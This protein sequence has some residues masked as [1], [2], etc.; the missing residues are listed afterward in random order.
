MSTQQSEHPLPLPDRLTRQGIAQVLADFFGAIASEGRAVTTAE[1]QERYEADRSKSFEVHLPGGGG[2][3][4]TAT[5]SVSHDKPKVED[6]NAFHE[7]IEA[8]YPPGTLIV[9]TVIRDGVQKDLFEKGVELVGDDVVS[10]KTGEVI[11]GLK[12][13][14]GGVPGSFSLTGIKAAKSRQA[15]LDFIDSEFASVQQL[16]ALEATPAPAP[17]D[18]EVVVSEVVPQ[19]G[20][21]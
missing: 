14:K 12:V 20:D 5:L 1:L 17:A 10:K 11:P 8:N 9:Q 18:G 21:E 3:F 16:L 6:E 15:V 13:E 7:W 2:M 19:G 4:A